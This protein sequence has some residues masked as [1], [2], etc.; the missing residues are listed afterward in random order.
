MSQRP[1]RCYTESHY[2]TLGRRRVCRLGCGR[3]VGNMLCENNEHGDEP[4]GWECHRPPFPIFPVVMPLIFPFGLM[5]ML[6]TLM[7]RRRSERPSPHRMRT[8]R[9][10][11]RRALEARLSEVEEALAALTEKVSPAEEE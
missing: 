8:G 2:H 3:G 7:R 9:G 1:Q 5:A 11:R 4:V 6:I 10:R